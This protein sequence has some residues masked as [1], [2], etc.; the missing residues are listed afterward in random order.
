MSAERPAVLDPSLDA[1]ILCYCTDLTFGALRSACERGA[2]PPAGKERTGRL[3]TG[4][5]GDLLYC[6]RALGVRTPE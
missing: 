6:L 1:E 3:C 5:Q 2:W 4:C